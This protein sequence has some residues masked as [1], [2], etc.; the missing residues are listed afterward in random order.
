VDRNRLYGFVRGILR[1]FGL[2]YFRMESVGDENLAASGPMLLVCNHASN[3]DP[4]FVGTTARRHMHFLAKEELFNIPLF[5]PFIARINAHPINRVGVDRRALRECQEILSGGGALVIFPE[6]TRTRDGKLQEAKPGGAMI[7]AQ[8]Q[9]P[10][11]PVYIE[12]SFEALP[13]GRWFPRPKKVR[14]HYGKPFNA[15]DAMKGAGRRE[16]YEALSAEMMR[17][18]AQL[19]P[20]RA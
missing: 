2:A 12:G 9:V 18:I 14:V 7:A 4:P 16:R 8:A 13:R 3:L 11:V 10:I 6:G 19:E 5:G 15:A 20:R 17:R 1:L